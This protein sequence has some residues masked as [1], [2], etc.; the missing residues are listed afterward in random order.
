MLSTGKS[1]LRDVSTSLYLM[2]LGASPVT[3]IEGRIGLGRGGGP[4]EVEIEPVSIFDDMHHSLKE[5]PFTGF[6]GEQ[7]A[8]AV[9]D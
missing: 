7:V 8:E 9:L 5:W 2:T 6:A 3:N 4:P 1:F